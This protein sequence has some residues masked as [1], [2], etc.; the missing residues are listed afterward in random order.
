MLSPISGKWIFLKSLENEVMTDGYN[1]LS[2]LMVVGNFR[3][4]G[5]GQGSLH[6]KISTLFL[7]CNGYPCAAG[8][9]SQFACRK[10][11]MI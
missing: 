1:I 3:I 10:E 9:L 2:F 11:T 8:K 4:V 7:P 5:R 6:T